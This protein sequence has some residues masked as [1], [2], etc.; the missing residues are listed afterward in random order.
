MSVRVRPLLLA[1]NSKGLFIATELHGQSRYIATEQHGQS[2][3][4]A[5]EQHG[6]PRNCHHDILQRSNTD[7]HGTTITIFQFRMYYTTDKECPVGQKSHKSFQI[8]Q[9]QICVTSARSR[10]T[11]YAFVTNYRISEFCGSLEAILKN[12]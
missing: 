6:Q 2:R 9:N 8:F 10:V 12:G 11:S 4:I 7:N 5:T 3:Y 1:T